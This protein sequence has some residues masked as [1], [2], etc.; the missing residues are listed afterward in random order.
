[1][2]S[3][4]RARRLGDPFHVRNVSG[5]IPESLLTSH[6]SDGARQS[7]SGNHCRSG[8]C[9]HV[10]NILFT[11][12]YI[13]WRQSV[14]HLGQTRRALLAKRA[15]IITNVG[16]WRVRFCPGRWIFSSKCV[17]PI[18]GGRLSGFFSGCTVCSPSLRYF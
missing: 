10:A 7:L 1:M 2:S 9:V 5:M 11:F 12:L 14:A 4:C 6:V 8:A 18:S 15:Y 17:I 16:G 3:R 13:Y